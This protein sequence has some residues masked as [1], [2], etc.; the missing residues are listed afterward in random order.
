[1]SVGLIHTRFHVGTWT[2]TVQTLSCNTDIHIHWLFSFLWNQLFCSCTFLTPPQVWVDRSGEVSSQHAND[3]AA[4]QGQCAHN[5]LDPGFGS[6]S[7]STGKICSDKMALSSFFVC[8]CP[9]LFSPFIIYLQS[10]IFG[11]HVNHLTLGTNPLQFYFGW[12][13]YQKKW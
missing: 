2:A 10:S 3:T 9:G 8:R 1:M 12:F 6:V 7:C 11:S 4:S 13:H 5:S